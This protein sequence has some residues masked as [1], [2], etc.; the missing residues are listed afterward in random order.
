MTVG[1][2]SVKDSV[3]G[4]NQDVVSALASNHLLRLLG[5]F[6]LPVC[7]SRNGIRIV[8]RAPEWVV[9]NTI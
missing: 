1:L 4:L 5:D 7:Y 9:G 8:N 3:V 2:S 6:A